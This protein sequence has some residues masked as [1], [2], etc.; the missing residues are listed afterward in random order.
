[1]GKLIRPVTSKEIE[2][3]TRNHPTKK[4]LGTESFIGEFYQIPIV[5]KLFQKTGEEGTLLTHS[6]RPGLHEHQSQI[7]M[8]QNS[9]N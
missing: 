1:M 9:T 5:L 4:S 8:L 3:L 6:I 2:S 7:G